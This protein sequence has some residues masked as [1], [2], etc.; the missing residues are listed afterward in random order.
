MQTGQKVSSATETIG[1]APGPVIS[2]IIPAL[3]EE[4]MIAKSLGSLAAADAAN[5][6]FE[7]IV[8][9]NGSTDRTLE[10][11]QGFAGRLSIR[12]VQKPSVPVT[13]LRNMGAMLARGEVVAF[14]DADC[15]VL[16]SWL[17]NAR[18]EFRDH[19]A[20]V[21]GGYIRIPEDATWVSRAWYGFGYAPRTG[22]VDY[23]PSGNLLMRRTDF[24]AIGG[25]DEHLRTAEDFDLCL[26]A[27]QAG[28]SVRAVADLAV[29]HLRSP[30]S[31]REFYK[32]ECWHG[33]HVT[34]ALRGN[35]AQWKRFR[36]A[37]FALFMLVCLLGALVE[38][39][40]GIATGNFAPLL[41]VLLLMVG[42]CVAG[43]AIKS[44]TA[45]RR[46][47]VGQFLQLTFL[48]FVYGIAR[49]QALLSV[50]FPYHR[51]FVPRVAKVPAE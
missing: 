27:R 33:S 22:D 32:R 13:A 21:V 46:V 24:F 6:S 2:V 50:S 31:L 1:S 44:K 25:F 4:E 9:D 41:M 17:V 8:V 37:A 23:V 10:L 42:P 12:T 16:K 14:L 15:Q 35:L 34:K 39:G 11:A 19:S 38:S 47:H 28:L 45:G 26:R 40:F 29:V 20:G 30:R 43:T 48:H 36:A 18:R 51:D 5:D 7:V 3:N 49:A